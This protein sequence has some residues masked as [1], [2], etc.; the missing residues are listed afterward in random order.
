MLLGQFTENQDTQMKRVKHLLSTD[1]NKS[2]VDILRE[3]LENLDKDQTATFFESVATLMANQVRELI[4]KSVKSYV[5]FF[6]R[7]RKP[8]DEYPSPKEIMTRE[9]DPD[10]P[11]EDN[12]LILNLSVNNTN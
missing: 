1:W 7:F 5:E 6:R 2:A 4:S 9:F 8:N 10:T 12:F 3:E 11:L